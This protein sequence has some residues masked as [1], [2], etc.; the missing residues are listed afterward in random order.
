MSLS[1]KCLAMLLAICLVSSASGQARD[2]AE[3]SASEIGIELDQILAN[4]FNRATEWDRV[5]VALMSLTGMFRRRPE[6]ALAQ[7]DI[8][9]AEMETLQFV[10][11]SWGQST[12]RDGDNRIARMCEVW[13]ASTLTGRDR[14]DA[15]LLAYERE[16]SN[17]YADF[18][19]RRV[20][21]LLAELERLL[22]PASWERLSE[23][24]VEQA[25]RPS[26]NVSHSFFT[27]T[28][29]NSQNVET[30]ELHCGN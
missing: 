16:I 4:Q 26:D 28:V 24:V 13:T 2:I 20:E 25:S 6:A 15:A 7:I 11:E 3:M 27:N 21:Q 18:T 30:M 29:R 12:D 17:G 8:P 9:Q 5:E 22:L 1:Q 10:F 23:Y 19:Q 14:F